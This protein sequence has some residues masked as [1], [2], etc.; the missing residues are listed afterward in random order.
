[1]LEL[2]FKQ[3]GFDVFHT[4]VEHSGDVVYTLKLDRDLSA[5]DPQQES[6]KP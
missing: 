6:E 3:A 2:L 5:E 4:A 1:M